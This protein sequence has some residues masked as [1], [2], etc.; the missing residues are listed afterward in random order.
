M[1]DRL[2]R[3][4]LSVHAGRRAA[5]CVAGTIVRSAAGLTSSASTV[6]SGLRL[7]LVSR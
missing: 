5:L 3:A 2:V 4:R 1:P 7:D 6:L